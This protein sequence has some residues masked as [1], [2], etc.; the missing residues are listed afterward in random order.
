MGCFADGVRA[1]GTC[2]RFLDA[3][4]SIEASEGLEASLVSACVIVMS[5]S[6]VMVMG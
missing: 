5:V 3:R 4:D 1:V 2:T 6:R